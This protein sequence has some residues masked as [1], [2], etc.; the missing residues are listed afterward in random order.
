M[1]AY[2]FLPEPFDHAALLPIVLIVFLL[3]VPPCGTSGTSIEYFGTPT[4]ALISFPSPDNTG[5]V[6]F[7]I[8][9]AGVIQQSALRRGILGGRLTSP[10]DAFSMLW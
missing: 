7:K 5:L 10:A 9:A 3:L 6:E 2:I 1:L 8:D 4:T